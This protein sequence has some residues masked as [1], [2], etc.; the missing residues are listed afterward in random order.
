MLGY[1]LG[2]DRPVQGNCG[3]RFWGSGPEV[4]AASGLGE[5]GQPNN[6]RRRSVR[7]C[8]AGPGSGQT[9]AGR[10]AFSLHPTLNS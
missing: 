2:R 5:N 1:G 7:N 9:E 10:Q 4:A 8:P 6:I 3:G